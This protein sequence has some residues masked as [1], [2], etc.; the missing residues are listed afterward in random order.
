MCY[1]D[2]RSTDLAV[3]NFNGV[4][5]GNNLIKVD[6]VKNYKNFDDEWKPYGPDGRG[7]DCERKFDQKEFEFIEYQKKVIQ[8]KFFEEKKFEK[9]KIKIDND[10]Y[11]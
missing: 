5:L 8:E 6:H 7:W 9:P 1:E 11:E 3:D 2:Q 10:F 4:K